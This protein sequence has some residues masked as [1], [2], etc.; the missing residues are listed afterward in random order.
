MPIKSHYEF[1][2][3][4][5]AVVPVPTL[6]FIIAPGARLQSLTPPPPCPRQR[7]TGS[8]GEAESYALARD[9][10][11]PRLTRRDVATKCRQ[12]QQQQQQQQPEQETHQ[13]EEGDEDD[14]ATGRYSSSDGGRRYLI[15]ACTHYQFSNRYYCVRRAA[16]TALLT[17]RTLVFPILP[18]MDALTGSFLDVGH[19]KAAHAAGRYADTFYDSSR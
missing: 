15:A 11:I 17:N 16:E 18:A 4:T 12:Q 3:V 5:F 7:L 10:L 19:L 1:C 14:A 13:E 2:T 9:A 6:Q 8:R